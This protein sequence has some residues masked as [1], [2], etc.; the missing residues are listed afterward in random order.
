MNSE[1]IF[2]KRFKA[3]Y[4]RGM[5]IVYVWI[6]NECPKLDELPSMQFKFDH[7]GRLVTGETRLATSKFD[8]TVAFYYNFF[9]VAAATSYCMLYFCFSY[10]Y[11]Y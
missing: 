1:Y 11:Y 8:Q 6:K 5:K 2:F 4:Q 7:A 9:N 10:L 3:G